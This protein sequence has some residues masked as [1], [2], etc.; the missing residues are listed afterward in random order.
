IR[1][2]IISILEPFVDTVIICNLTALV[3]ITTGIYNDVVEVTISGSAL[4][5]L[6]FGQ[7]IN[8]AP[9]VLAGVMGVFAFSKMITWC[10]YDERCWAYVFGESNRPV[11]KIIFL[12]FI[13]L[14]SIIN[15]EA[16]VNFSDIMLL[17]L[18][19]A[20]ILGCIFLSGQVAE[21]L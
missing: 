5:V 2:G 20:N 21:D 9:F 12:I 8:W 17:T 14:G 10:Y 11:F 1:E 19:I 13:F 15:L 16:V 3:I 4:A 7:V 18:A 6:A